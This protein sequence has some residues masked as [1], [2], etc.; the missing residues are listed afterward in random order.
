METRHSSLVRSCSSPPATSFGQVYLCQQQR[1]LASDRRPRPWR[2]D[3][4]GVVNAR[5]C[6]T[7]CSDLLLSFAPSALG[8]STTWSWRLC[9]TGVGSRAIAIGLLQRC[10][11]RSPSGNSGTAAASPTRQRDSSS[12]WN[13]VTMQLPPF[14]S[15]IGYPLHNWSSTSCVCLFTS[16]SSACLPDSAKPLT[17]D[18]LRPAHTG[19]RHTNTLV[20]ACLRQLQPLSPTDGAAIWRPC[21]LCRRAPC[22]ESVADGTETHAVIDNNIQ[23]SPKNVSVQLSTLLSLTIE[24]AIGLIVGGALQMLLLLLLLLWTMFIGLWSWKSHCV[25]CVFFSSFYISLFFLNPTV[26][27]KLSL[28][29]VPPP[30]SL[31]WRHLVNAYE[32]MAGSRGYLIHGPLY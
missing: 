13:R 25:V 30:L 19:R 20:A 31:R 11:C 10:S 15:C 3:R 23:A 2:V 8:S 12:T 18:Y 22:V 24:C 21:V 6:L 5:A 28:G 26:S 27:S 7:C 4:L 16:H 9:K 14:A 1:R 29:C 17:P 32:V